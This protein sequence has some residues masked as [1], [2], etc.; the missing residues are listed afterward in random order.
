MII[1]TDDQQDPR[2]QPTRENIIRA[3]H[4]LVKDARANDSLFFH[5]SGHGGQTEDLD[6]DESDGLDETIYPVDFKKVGMIVD[7]VLSLLIALT[8]RKCMISWSN[9]CRRDVAS[10]PFSIVVTPVQPSIFHTNM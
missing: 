8:I 1:L 2:F 6:G 9:H 3:M 10:P 4:W 5:F 7:D